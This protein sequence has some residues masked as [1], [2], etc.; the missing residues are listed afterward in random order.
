MTDTP[1]HIKDLQLKLWLS[2]TPGERLYQ[3]LMDNDAMYQALREFKI[4]MNFPLDGLDP[5]GEY[6][7]KKHEKIDKPEKA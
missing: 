5:V 3:F 7:K 1:Q 4:R 6:L 2:K